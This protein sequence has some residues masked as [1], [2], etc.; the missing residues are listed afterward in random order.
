M[1]SPSGANLQLNPAWALYTRCG[2]DDR[3]ITVAAVP[4]EYLVGGRMMLI[5]L[6]QL[7]EVFDDQSTPSRSLGE[8]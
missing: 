4:E 7:I 5:I 6:P 1:I 8:N 2:G 3:K